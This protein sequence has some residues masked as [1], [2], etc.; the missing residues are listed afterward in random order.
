[1]SRDGEFE[2]KY[3]DREGQERAMRLMEALSGVDERLLE[4]CG[5]ERKTRPLWRNMRAVAAAACLAAVGAV[6]WGEYQAV[7][8]EDGQRRLCPAVQRKIA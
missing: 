6:S 4:R 5:R 1:M 2:K 3:P 7:Q 8:S